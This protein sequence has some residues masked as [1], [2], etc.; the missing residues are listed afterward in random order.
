MKVIVITRESRWGLPSVVSFRGVTYNL[1]SLERLGS[2]TYE[3]SL[4]GLPV[5]NGVDEQGRPSVLAVFQHDP[6]NSL[7]GPSFNTHIDLEVE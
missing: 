2:M 4:G 5:V 6:G 1:P 7:L 3:P